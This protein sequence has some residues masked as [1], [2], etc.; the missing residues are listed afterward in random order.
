VTSKPPHSSVVHQCARRYCKMA[1]V[2][3]AACCSSVG[4]L[5][6]HQQ[7]PHWWSGALQ[8]AASSPRV[9]APFA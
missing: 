6:W 7:V 9:Q 8:A 3:V 2:F 4:V 1:C 5:L